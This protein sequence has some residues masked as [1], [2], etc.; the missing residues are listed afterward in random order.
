MDHHYV[1][2]IPMSYNPGLPGRPSGVLLRVLPNDD[3]PFMVEQVVY[4]AFER[5]FLPT[6]S[7]METIISSFFGQSDG[8]VDGQN[9][10]HGV[11]M[12]QKRTSIS[13]YTGR[14]MSGSKVW[15]LVRGKSMI[16]V[17]H[18]MT[19]IDYSDVQNPWL[20]EMVMGG[21][22]QAFLERHWGAESR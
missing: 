12:K 1:L 14:L 18:G 9:P 10:S 7:I 22:V 21:P 3:C 11:V 19:E 20:A 4:S 16:P 17:Y 2:P 15:C 5:V 6:D 8:S 13:F